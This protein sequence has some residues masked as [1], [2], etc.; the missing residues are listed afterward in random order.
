MDRQTSLIA[1]RFASVLSNLRIVE[2]LVLFGSRARGDNFVTSDFD[3]VAV[4]GNFA[5]IRFPI[6]S[7]HLL[8]YWDSPLE[9]EILCYT[10]KEW[11]KLKNRR[12]ILRNA[13]SEGI[14][15]V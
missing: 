15:L 12:G 5:D 7:S 14:R 9:A 13:Q 6:R 10:P 3:F 4:S 8:E 2:R 1:R 11:T